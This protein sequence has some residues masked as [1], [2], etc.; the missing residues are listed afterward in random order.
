MLPAATL[1]PRFVLW[2]AVRLVLFQALLSS[3]SGVT[4]HPQKTIETG[5]FRLDPSGDLKKAVAVKYARSETF[6]TEVR[7]SR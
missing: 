2:L 1:L 3:T 7:C 4:V 5:S 6:L